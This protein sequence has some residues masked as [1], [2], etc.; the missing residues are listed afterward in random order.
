MH[1]S[2]NMC[3]VNGQRQI[4]NQQRAVLW[5]H[6]MLSGMFGKCSVF[7]QFHRKEG[8]ALM[9]SDFVDLHDS[10][11]SQRRAGL[12]FC[13]KPHDL[14]LCRELRIQNQLQRDRAIELRLSRPIDNAHAAA[15][16]LSFDAI[17]GNFRYARDRFSSQ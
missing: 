10:R 3:R 17:A 5:R 13:Q 8:N 12:S 9:L 14:F 7:Q 11:M 4:R 2:L 6:A 1:D 15:A 16:E